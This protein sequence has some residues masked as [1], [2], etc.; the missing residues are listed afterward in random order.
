MVRDL[1]DELAEWG[2][3]LSL[4]ERVEQVRQIVN[5]TLDELINPYVYAEAA[6]L[7]GEH[8]GAGRDVVLVST[9]GD[10][11]VRRVAGRFEGRLQRA[12]Q[13]PIDRQRGRLRKCLLDHCVVPGPQC[14]VHRG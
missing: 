5:E 8:R 3:A 11:M 14:L 12:G 4:K 1:A 9:S 7:I 6:A 2:D 13:R 10:E